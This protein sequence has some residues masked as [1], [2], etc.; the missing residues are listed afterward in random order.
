MT[1]LFNS[2]IN[3][4]FKA[5]HC[6]LHP[7]CTALEEFALNLL[8]CQRREKERERKNLC[9]KVTHTITYMDDRMNT[10]QVCKPKS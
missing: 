10:H 4:L 9:V 8:Q 1:L 7:E 3:L 5:F 2:K 6:Q